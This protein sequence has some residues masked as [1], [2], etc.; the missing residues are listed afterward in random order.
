MAD[1]AFD[2][3]DHMKQRYYPEPRGTCQRD[4]NILEYPHDSL[5]KC[6]ALDYTSFKNFQV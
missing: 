2:P 3:Y 4:K 5:R 6:L 1:L